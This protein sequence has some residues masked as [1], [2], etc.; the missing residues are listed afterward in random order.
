MLGALGGERELRKMLESMEKVKQKV[1]GGELG[2]VSVNAS[3][4]RARAIQFQ[5][6]AP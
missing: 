3:R 1:L 2:E 4:C 6:K 5:H